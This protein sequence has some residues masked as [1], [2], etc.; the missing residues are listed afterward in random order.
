MVGVRE[1]KTTGSCDTCDLFL[2][3]TVDTITSDHVVQECNRLLGGGQ[4]GGGGGGE[5]QRERERERECVCVCV[6]MPLCVCVC[7]C[8]YV[9]ACVHAHTEGFERLCSFPP[10]LQSVTNPLPP[11]FKAAGLQTVKVQSD[12]DRGPVHGTLCLDYT[13]LRPHKIGRCV[14]AKFPSCCFSPRHD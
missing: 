6:C 2:A 3:L 5:R 9:R 8:V 4:G 11:S 7:V 14:A 13:K 1:G 10:Q 12:C